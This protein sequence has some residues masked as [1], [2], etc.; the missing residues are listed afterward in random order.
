MAS[1]QTSVSQTKSCSTVVLIDT[2]LLYKRGVA[3]WV[4]TVIVLA[5]LPVM[6]KLSAS[7]SHAGFTSHPLP[8]V[9]RDK[10]NTLS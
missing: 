10:F 3:G 8:P 2:T 5:M 9:R 4:G 7:R 1:Q 6:S